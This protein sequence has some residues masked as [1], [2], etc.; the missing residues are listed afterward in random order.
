MAAAPNPSKKYKIA[1]VYPYFKRDT[2]L[3]GWPLGLGYISSF[4]KTRSHEA[5]IFHAK[6]YDCS[7]ER[8][9]S[10]IKEY[11]PDYVGIY[12][13][14]A[15]RYE[16][17]SFIT[18]LKANGHKILA[19]GPDPTLRPELYIGKSDYVVRGEGEYVL[20]NFLASGE[21]PV[22]GMA[23]LEN[24]APVILDRE[25]SIQN[26]DSLP[27]PE[28][29]AEYQVAIMTSRSCPFNCTFCQPTLHLLFGK[30]VRFRTAK[31]VV[32]EIEQY[33]KKGITH[34]FFLDENFT[35]YTPHLS[36]ICSEIKK[37]NINISW[38][39][40]ARVNTID[41]EKIKILKDAGCTELKFGVES[42]SQ[43]IL[44]DIYN[45]GIT[46]DQIKQ[47][48]QLCQKYDLLATAYIM[49]GAPTETKE[50]FN[51]TLNLLQEIRPDGIHVSITT[52]LPNTHL[53]DKF[54]HL[55]SAEEKIH[56]LSFASDNPS[57]CLKWVD[58]SVTFD[59]ILEYKARYLQVV[60]NKARAKATN[61]KIR[62]FNILFLAYLR[63][64]LGKNYLKKCIDACVGVTGDLRMGTQRAAAGHERLI[65]HII[66]K[67][68]RLN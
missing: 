47:A 53:Y 25:E 23:Y 40:Q 60:V 44:T 37:R 55:L 27:F 4:L 14:Y 5:K 28:Q 36:A 51:A 9:L 42:G 57:L 58:K 35:V 20:S 8:M 16:C 31:N 32:D 10:A 45:K 50:D 13:N 30:N 7:K 48:F 19:G 65:Y 39:T 56:T 43:R 61:K 17:I 12:S 2:Y 68:L 6:D 3:L 63:L 34:F 38:Y 52:I 15:L 59:D 21:K 18:L 33:Y 49:I 62:L 11:K 66:G 67:I 1:L 22:K 41:E 64:T 29:P 54:E 46:L 24:G 26:L